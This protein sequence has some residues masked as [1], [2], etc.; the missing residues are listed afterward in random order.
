MCK[1]EK[2][3]VYNSIPLPL[4]H[5]HYLMLA[6]DDD[7]Q[8]IH[9]LKLMIE[10]V[11]CNIIFFFGG[12][13]GNTFKIALFISLQ[14][15]ALKC[16][17]MKLRAPTGIGSTVALSHLVELQK[18]LKSLGMNRPSTALLLSCIQQNH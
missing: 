12:G 17:F 9:S 18:E 7:G 8:T 3:C 11:Q 10:L 1:V 5:S 13:G 14:A 6:A 15:V 2:V 16:K 4:E